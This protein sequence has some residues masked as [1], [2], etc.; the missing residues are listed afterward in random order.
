MTTT[1]I[2]KPAWPLWV[3]AVI[4]VIVNGLSVWVHSSGADPAKLALI[5]GALFFD[6][7]VT[8]PIAYYMLAIRGADRPVGTFWLVSTLCLV[9]AVW[10]LPDG[11][12]LRIAAAGF[13][14]VAVGAVVFTQVRKALK[15]RGGH[16]DPVDSIAASVRSLIPSDIVANALS[17]ELAVFYYAFARANKVEAPRTFTIHE[18]SGIRDIAWA[19]AALSVVETGIVHYLLAK[20]NVGAAWVLTAFSIYGGIWM[21]ALARSFAMRPIIVDETG[22]LLRKG[23]L[24][25]L[26]VPASQIERIDVE[27][28][29]ASERTIDFAVWSEPALFIRTRGPVSAQG[30]FGMRRAVS[31]VGVDPDDA[32]GF[33]AALRE[34]GYISVGK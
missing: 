23:I 22:I 15:H 16:S 25:R 2:A 17:T 34:F 12:S 11:S 18:R 33:E 19:I 1:R 8:L 20:W 21:I 27:K 24:W 30:P 4:A 5:R 3:F 31:V 13:V 7:A 9:R 28:P 32:S 10:M 26:F 14:E 6:L 29:G